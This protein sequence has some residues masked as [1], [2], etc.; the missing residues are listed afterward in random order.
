MKIEAFSKTYQGRTVLQFP[1]GEFHPG[2]LYAILGPN[3]SG[4]STFA[5]VVS[6]V[7]DPDR[8]APVVTWEKEDAAAAGKERIG[9]LTQRPYA[10]HMSLMK[11][12]L[13]NG[14]GT[15]EQK[16]NKAHH[17]MNALSLSSL[18]SKNAAL[19]SGG[20]T[21]RMALARLFM[22]KYR[23][24]ILDEPFAAMDIRS[25]YQAEDL[26]REYLKE[27]NCTLFLII[28]NLHQAERLADEVLFFKDGRLIGRGPAPQVLHH[29]ESDQVR[30]IL[31]F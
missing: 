31:E 10:F 11:N 12:L 1:G 18:E 5:G 2:T 30:E 6:G 22:K 26:I 14:E 28:H 16:K 4:K 29:P 23:L 9:L 21:G 7:T 19:F 13:L 24:V 25:S 15:K 27:T 17:L 3:G 20:E 8:K